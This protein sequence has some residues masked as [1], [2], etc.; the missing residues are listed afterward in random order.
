MRKAAALLVSTVLATGGVLATVSA[1]GASTPAKTS[2]FCKAVKKTDYENIGNP[3]SKKNSPP[4]C[5]VTKRIG[6]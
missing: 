5:S 6:A 3:L 1:A 4:S 2:K